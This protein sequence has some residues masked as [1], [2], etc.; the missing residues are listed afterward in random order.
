MFSSECETTFLLHLRLVGA[1]V[2]AQESVV[3]VIQLRRLGPIEPS[4]IERHIGSWTDLY[5]HTPIIIQQEASRESMD[6]PMDDVEDGDGESALDTPITFPAD[7]YLFWTDGMICRVCRTE[8]EP[9]HP[10]FHP[11]KC[12]GSIRYVHSDW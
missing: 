2:E 6:D 12:S 7:Q 5:A 8:A 10:L 4:G 9:D 1:A 3:N 11:C